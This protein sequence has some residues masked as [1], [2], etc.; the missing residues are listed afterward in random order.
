LLQSFGVERITVVTGYG[1]SHVEQAVAG[2]AQLVHNA[3]W[4]DTNSA[5]SLWLCRDVVRS[6]L[7][8]MNCDVLVHPEILCRILKQPGSA[9]AYD[10]SS[11]VEAEHMMVEICNNFLSSMGKS[12]PLERSHG[13]NVGVLYFDAWPA[14]VL[15]REAG[16]LVGNGGRNQWLAAAVERVA[17]YVPLHGIDIS[18][19]PWIEVDFPEDLE[20]ARQQVWP[21]IEGRAARVRTTAARRRAPW[22]AALGQPS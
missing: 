3:H 7:V 19:L 16:K 15:F 2:R 10:S 11:G 8:V 6:P 21:A 22:P 9:F 18:D 1:A 17:E 4:R 12:M 5:Y 13:E 20:R 14:H